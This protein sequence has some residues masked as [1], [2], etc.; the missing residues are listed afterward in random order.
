MKLNMSKKISSNLFIQYE[1]NH[2]QF[3]Y[4]TSLFFKPQNRNEMPKN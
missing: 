1:N 4:F 3:C 2:S